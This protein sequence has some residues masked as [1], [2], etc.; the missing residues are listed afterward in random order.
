[1]VNSYKVCTKGLGQITKEW[2]VVI[3]L[4]LNGV[5]TGAAN[6]AGEDSPHFC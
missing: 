1:M 5:A 6:A 2:N 3:I 4:G